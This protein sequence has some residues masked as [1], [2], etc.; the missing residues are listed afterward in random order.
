M[1]LHFSRS[2]PLRASALA[3]ALFVTGTSAHAQACPDWRMNGQTITTDAETAWAPQSFAISA[4]GSL[5]LSACTEVPGYGYTGAAPSFTLTY[6]DRGLGRDLDFRVEA[7]NCDTVMLINDYGDTWSF[8]DDEDG[9]L[10]PRLRM[11][12]APSG[13]YDIWVGTFGPQAC[14]ATLIVETFPPGADG[15]AAGAGQC[16][17]WSLGGTDL[18]LNAGGATNQ[19]VVAGGGVNLFANAASCGFD[20]V[21]YVAT[22]PDFTLAYDAPQANGELILSVTSECDTVLL[23]NDQ[24]ANWMFNDDTNGFNPAISIPAAAGGRYDIWVGTY[25][26][27]LC[28]ANLEIISL[29]M[30]DP[31]PPPSL[32]K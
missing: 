4:G 9:T 26:D 17:D 19:R 27:A 28:E 23:V 12:A 20:G 8:N 10:N 29:V 22:A 21:G 7:G 14:Q 18:Q 3:A 5:D 30:S 32:S 25:G 11:S 24:A 2:V 1:I 15:A 6:D 16:P 13:R 31:S